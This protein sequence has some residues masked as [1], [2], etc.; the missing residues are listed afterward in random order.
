MGKQGPWTQVKWPVFV[1][2]IEIFK[3]MWT[4]METLMNGAKCQQF[5][6][7]NIFWTVFNLKRQILQFWFLLSVSLF[8]DKLISLRLNFCLNVR[9]INH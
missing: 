2:D 5:K 1:W 7:I 4:R 6:Y 9:E 8:L 3:D